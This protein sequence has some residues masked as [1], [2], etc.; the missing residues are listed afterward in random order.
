M[1]R[2]K[3]ASTI[4]VTDASNKKIAKRV[5]VK[6]PEFSGFLIK[7]RKEVCP[8]VGY[9]TA[10]IHLINSLVSGFADRLIKKTGELARYDKTHKGTMKA[11]HAKTASNMI[12]VGP[13][14]GYA[15]DK[16]EDAVQRFLSQDGEAS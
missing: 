11:K 14:S 7:I 13:L 6:A 16:A 2:K 5:I 1:A 9:S 4:S 8:E 12:L 10:S 15:I 3:T